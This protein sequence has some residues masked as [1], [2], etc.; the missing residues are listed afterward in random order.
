[1][2]TTPGPWNTTENQEVGGFVLQAS[3]PL[4]SIGIVRYHRPTEAYSKHR[5]S[6]DRHPGHS[7]RAYR[8][9]GYIFSHADG[10]NQTQKQ[11]AHA[12]GLSL[13]TVRGALQDLERDG[14]LA[15]QR[16][17]EGGRWIG[18]AYAVSDIPFTEDELAALCPPGAD[19]EHSES[20][21]HKKITTSEKTKKNNPSGG[22]TAA[23]APRSLEPSPI[24]E[25]RQ[26]DA[27]APPAETLAL[28]DP[29]PSVK[30]QK[31]REPS[32]GTVVA[33][34][35]D[36]YRKAHS[37]ADPVKA[38][39]GRVARDAKMLIETGRAAPQELEKAATE[40]G[41]TS[42]N[43]LPVSLDK[44]REAPKRGRQGAVPAS[45]FSDPHW[46]EIAV[47]QDRQW[48][49]DLLTD[50][51]SIRWARRDQSEVDKLI[52]R[53]PELAARFRDVA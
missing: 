32:A 7:L 45:P 5:N 16:I 46:Q 37:G 40:M 19:F 42:Y 6:F 48:Y 8:V 28:F 22:A 51:E 12:C 29:P 11:I 14:Y 36:A 25:Q 10:F 35:V 4:A 53:Y 49:Q 9:A 47:E 26:E 24:H 31:P 41:G 34:F 17:R 39:I 1:V 38:A 27:V 30:A 18:T 52:A 2:L 3:T 44:L 15:R 23:A 50:D 13:N 33:A 20:A 21:P 43:N